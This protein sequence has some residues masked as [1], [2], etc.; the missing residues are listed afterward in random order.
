MAQHTQST[1]IPSVKT[2]LSQRIGLKYPLVSAP[3]FLIST[4]EMLISSAEAGI[5]GAM[6]SLNGRSHDDFKAMLREVRSATENPFAINLTIGLTDPKRIKADLFA[7]IDH[8]VKVLITSYGDPTDIVK[9]AHR[10][11]MIVLH[12]VISLKHALKAQRAGVDAIIG[13]SAGAGGHGGTISPFAFIPW[14]K[15]TLSIPIVAAGAISTGHQVL[16]ALSLGAELCYM[17][18]RFIV[19]DECSAVEEYKKMIQTATP[20]DI[21]YTDAVSGISANFLKASLPEEGPRTRESPRKRWRDIWSAGHG[22]AQIQQT[23][24]LK[25]IVEQV[26]SE[27]HQALTQINEATEGDLHL[28]HPSQVTPKRKSS[29]FIS[30]VK[31]PRQPSDIFNLTEILIDTHLKTDQAHHTALICPEGNWTYVSVYFHIQKYIQRLSDRSIRQEERVLISIKDSADFVA[32]LLAC[33]RYGAVGVMINPDLDPDRIA[34]LVE[35]SRASC[36]FVETGSPLDNFTKA[37]SSLKNSVINHDEFKLM[38]VEGSQ[39]VT[40]PSY[41]TH[42]DN[43]VPPART[44]RDDPAIW[45]FSGGTTGRP[46]AI[47]QPHRSFL[48]TTEH[49][50]LGVMAY[51]KNDITL[52]VPKLYFGYATGA[53]LI[54]PMAAGGSTI[55]FADRPTPEKLFE[56][57]AEHRPTILIN[58]PTII[59]RMVNHPQA[60]QQDLSCLRVVTS[61]GEALP[62]SLS[63]KWSSLYEAPLCDGLGTAEMWHIFLTNHPHDPSQRKEGTLGKVVEGF[64]ISLRNPDDLTQEVP[65]NTPGVMWVKGGARALGYWQQIEASRKAFIGEWYASGDLMMK[66]QDGFYTF[67]G[68]SDD[69]IK[70][71]GKFA[72]PKEVEDCLMQNASIK[73][74]AVVGR[75]DKTGLMKLFAFVTINEPSTVSEEELINELQNFLSNKL[76][77]YKLPK[78]IFILKDFPKTHLGKINRGSLSIH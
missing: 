50:A 46:K 69:M 62:Q 34:E 64:E 55:L 65:L 68:R 37:L 38:S 61:A 36:A 45:L 13:V 28:N 8:G 63:E 23:A 31:A 41:P 24:P 56:L 7:C 21:V 43:I 74:C 70:V 26:M 33:V 5:L 54:F 27:Y 48:Y 49:Y 12:D 67:C 58:V 29:E 47:V 30:L 39:R 57:I 14:L 59:N 76:D 1:L 73:E 42:V 4:P 66:D 20:E 9:E 52:S 17:G 53:N 15:S 44:H 16:S 6:P 2:K 10:H 75:A 19:S 51:D 3:M 22:V 18:T 77:R 32:A 78:N 71:A 60:T 72:S 35:Y 40:I 25:T 11:N